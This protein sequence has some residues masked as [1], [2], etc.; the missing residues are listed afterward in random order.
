M[1]RIIIIYGL[2]AGTIVG[3]LMLITMPM[4]KQGTLNMDNGE[5]LGYTTMVI[6]LSMVFFGVKSYRDNYLQG[7]ITF[8]GGFKAGILITVVASIMYALAWEISYARMGSGFMEQMVD[9]SLEKM[10]AG[11]ATEIDL[12]KSRESWA[13]FLEMYKNPVIRFGVTLME[14]FPV[15]LG[16]TLL[17]AALLRRKG[18]LPATPE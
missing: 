1:K 14:I 11:G 17:S 9:R 7:V 12:Q 5:L 4:Y 2:I 6:A 8:W 15:G 18:F 3:A 13:A 10:K 16:I